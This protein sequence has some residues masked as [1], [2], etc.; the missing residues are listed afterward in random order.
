M[1]A[2]LIA[3][4]RGRIPGQASTL[5]WAA[6]V[7]GWLL[8]GLLG[9]RY[10]VGVGVLALAI[11]GLATAFN[12]V[13]GFTGLL[14]LAQAGL[15]GIGGY[16]SALL[17]TRLG[18]PI[19]AAVVAA[20]LFG[21]V[22]ALLLGHPSLRLSKPAFIIVSLSFTMLVQIIA[23]GW[24]DLTRGPLGIPGLPAPSLSWGGLDIEFDR[25]RG[26]YFLFGA[27]VIVVVL[28]FW[29]LTRSRIATALLAVRDDPALAESLGLKVHRIRLGVFVVAGT[30]TS[31]LGG[32]FV[33]HLSIVDPSIFGIFYVQ[34]IVISVVVGGRASFW[35]AIVA[36]IAFV[37]LPEVF[38]MTGEARL[39]A[40]GAVLILVTFFL[41][42][43]V[44]GLVRKRVR[45]RWG[46][47][48]RG[49]RRVRP[50]ELDRS[51]A[52]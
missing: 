39:V 22:V 47:S 6:L 7:V 26:T 4:L 46:T 17:V 16:T 3:K 50:E 8:F 11:V 51:V 12:M 32:L 10:A 19:W 41:P 38:R 44:A 29:Q 49:G 1:S 24:V 25:P 14:S 15:W 2:A 48:G 40:F 23:R 45:G 42:N 27:L 35:G 28:I 5:G 52:R 36:A 43:G 30:V 37:A 13:Y 34:A 20:M 18:L 21:G 9:S 33:F 31:M